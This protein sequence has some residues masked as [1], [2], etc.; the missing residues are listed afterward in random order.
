MTAI[1][2]VN[3][4]D[5]RWHVLRNK[6]RGAALLV[7][8]DKHIGVHGNQVVHRVQNRFA[9]GLRRGADIQ[10]KHIGRQALGSN[11]K[12]GACARTV[13]KE[14]IANGFATQQRYFLDFT[15]SHADKV[16]GRIQ[17]VGQDTLG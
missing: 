2:S 9:F 3:D 7:T 17:D 6:V 4:A 10:V 16:F 11:F 14:N 15:F 8:H 13:L 1:A 12:R 5:M